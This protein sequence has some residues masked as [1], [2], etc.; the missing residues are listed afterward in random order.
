MRI[1]CRCGK[2]ASTRRPCRACDSAS[3]MAHC[4]DRAHMRH[5]IRGEAIGYQGESL[6]RCEAMHAHPY[7][8]TDHLNELQ[9]D[10]DQSTT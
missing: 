5:T 9:H 6:G 3:P 10:V 2:I 7:E 4:H 8:N 1:R